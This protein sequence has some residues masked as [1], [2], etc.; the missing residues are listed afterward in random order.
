[1]KLLSVDI[2]VR[3][4]ALCVLECTD[5]GLDIVKWEVI[6]LFPPPRCQ[7]C[8]AASASHELKGKLYCRKCAARSADVVLPTPSL[9]NACKAPYDL[10]VLRRRGLLLLSE[11]LTATALKRAIA[12]RLLKAHK[13]RA[14]ST[15]PLQE[16]AA[17]LD[18]RFREFRS[19]DNYDLVVIENQIGPQAIRMKAIQAMLTQLIVSSASTCSW[20]QIVYISAKEKLKGAAGLNSKGRDYGGRK[21]L[22]VAICRATLASDSS[23]RI[24]LETFESHP[25]KDD[26]ADAYLQAVAAARD[27]GYTPPVGWK[28]AMARIT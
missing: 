6:D 21:E 17:A 11:D 26:L 2:G 20:E 16:V 28:E 5:T 27:R 1:M 13:P 14:A 12:Q 3:N 15:I 10:Q 4:L 9:L 7:Y 23:S 25:K 24:W 19:D 22:A 18:T 8:S